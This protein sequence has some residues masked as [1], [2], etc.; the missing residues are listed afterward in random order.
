LSGKPGVAP[1]GYVQ[2]DIVLGDGVTSWKGFQPIKIGDDGSEE[3]GR[4]IGVENDQWIQADQTGSN[5]FTKKGTV[6]S[7]TIPTS[8]LGNT[9]LEFQ[10]ASVGYWTGYYRLQGLNQIKDRS[11]VIFTWVKPKDQ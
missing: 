6:N 4:Q 5:T 11:Q 7:I 10:K 8:T 1:S 2:L 3:W 9:V